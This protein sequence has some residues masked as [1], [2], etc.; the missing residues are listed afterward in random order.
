MLRQ[1]FVNFR[2][3]VH[4][5]IVAL[6]MHCT[7]ESFPLVHVLTLTLSA[8]AIR[9]IL[10][11]LGLE[12]AGYQN[13]SRTGAAL[14]FCYLMYQCICYDPPVSPFFACVME[15]TALSEKMMEKC[16][17]FLTYVGRLSQFFATGVICVF[18]IFFYGE[19]RLDFRMWRQELMLDFRLLQQQRVGLVADGHN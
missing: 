12:G 16:W 15:I 17:D 5:T 14:F 6:Y 1:I 2:H 9:V 10:Q 7:M 11:K 4:V 19:L 13:E 18:V 3:C 8:V